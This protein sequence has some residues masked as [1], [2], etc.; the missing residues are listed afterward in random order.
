MRH[1]A[2]TMLCNSMVCV[3]LDTDDHFVAQAISEQSLPILISR[4]RIQ[5]RHST[6]VLIIHILYFCLVSAKKP[7]NKQERPCPS[8]PYQNVPTAMKSAHTSPTR[9][10]D[11]PVSVTPTFSAVVCYFITPCLMMVINVSPGLN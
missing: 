1:F 5:H 3:L 7:A 8:L 2:F 4:D 11:L 10:S 6:V 9:K